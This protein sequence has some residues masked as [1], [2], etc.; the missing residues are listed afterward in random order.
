MTAAA[1][2]G[3][4]DGILVDLDGTLV[5][6]TA[7]V[8]RAWGAFADRQGLDREAV[9][10]LA[11]GRPSRETIGLLL[12]P[13]ADRDAET[14]RLEEGEVSDTDGVF[15]LPGA[16]RL[17]G[18]DRRLAIVTSCSTA[19]AEARLRAAGLPL[20]GVLVSSDGLE[21]GK[22]DPAC[23]VIAARS[24][25]TDPW[26]CVVIEDSPAGIR[27]GREAG[28]TVIALRTTHGDDALGEAHAIVDDIGAL[29]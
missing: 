10:R 16:A 26:R 23:F 27:A 17:L 2:F 14:G 1:L 12:A 20:P 22:P 9:H 18:S 29:V 13:G 3:R 15:A 28:A 8:G 21:R 6:S 24:L 7:P 11:Q 25:G 4:A 19:L 5:D